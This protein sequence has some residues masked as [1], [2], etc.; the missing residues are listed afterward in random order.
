M[1][2]LLGV[3]KTTANLV[4]YAELGYPSLPDLIMHRQH[5]FYY[6]VVRKT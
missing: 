3:K 1:K 5:K 2:E 6:N 4:C